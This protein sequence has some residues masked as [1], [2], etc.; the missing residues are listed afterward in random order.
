MQPAQCQTELPVDPCC[1]RLSVIN[2]ELLPGELKL[3]LISWAGAA[4]PLA[5]RQQPFALDA[6]QSK[7]LLTMHQDQ[8]LTYSATSHGQDH[9]SREA[10]GELSCPC[11]SLTRLCPEATITGQTS[12]S[13]NVRSKA[14]DSKERCTYA[15]R[16]NGQPCASPH[17]C[18]AWPLWEQ[19]DVSQ[20][21]HLE[22][23][24]PHECFLHVTGTVKHPEG[25]TSSS[26]EEAKTCFDH[27][28]AVGSDSVQKT[29][30]DPL[31]I[32]GGIQADV[33]RDAYTWLRWLLEHTRHWYSELTSSLIWLS[34]FARSA[35]MQSQSLSTAEDAMQIMWKVTSMLDTELQ[36]CAQAVSDLVAPPHRPYLQGLHATPSQQVLQSLA[37][38]PQ[39]SDAQVFFSEFKDAS[40]IKPNISI[41]DIRSLAP[42]VVEFGLVT[43]QVAAFVA[44]ETNLSGRFSEN[45]LLLLPWEHKSLAFLSEG[46]VQAASLEDTLT[47]LTLSDTAIS[48]Y[49]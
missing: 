41:I 39:I 44:L 12:T 8:L 13:K 33:S 6:L 4:G 3:E 40:V 18:K 1:F 38:E 36:A 21:H 23:C 43:D 30:R 34:S 32:D 16:G 7:Q 46:A 45:G 47:V 27:A 15:K 11:D 5:C 14:T 2:S 48:M 31:H 19:T 26:Y 20:E 17:G 37:A 10:S 49:F 22:E 9:D 24:S 35:M 28:T 29:V 42:S 25:S